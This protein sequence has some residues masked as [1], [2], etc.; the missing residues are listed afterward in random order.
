LSDE[1]CGLEALAEKLQIPPGPLSVL[2]STCVALRLLTWDGQR[3]SN[4][5][6]AQHFL[7]RTTPSYVGDYYLRQISALIYSSLPQVRS[8]LRGESQSIARDYASA[9]SDPWTTEEFVRGQ[10][11]GSLGPAIMLSRSLDLAGFSRLLDL[12]GGSGAFAIELVKRSSKLHDFAVSADR[13]GPQ[14]A[15]LF[16]FGQLTVSAQT[17]AYTI[18]ELKTALQEAGYH[19]ITVQPFIPDLTFL[20]RA[21]KPGRVKS[22]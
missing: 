6:A 8:L 2:L 19:Q 5:P 14:N 15:A 21:S 4:S 10:H 11:A 13:G 1:P 7:V 18:D 22:V 12:G 9:L 17:Q 3:Y 20:I 16:L